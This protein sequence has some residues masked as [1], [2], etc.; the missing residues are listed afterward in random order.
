MD[1]ESRRNFNEF[2]QPF[3]QSRVNSRNYR[4]FHFQIYRFKPFAYL[5]K[6]KKL[7]KYRRI[8]PS[9]LFRKFNLRIIRCKISSRL[10]T[11]CLVEKFLHPIYYLTSKQRLVLETVF[12]Q[13]ILHSTPLELHA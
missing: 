12:G 11:I 4:V 2:E 8:F 7:P 9:L 1:K 10:Y 5:Q 6:K 3:P 13:G